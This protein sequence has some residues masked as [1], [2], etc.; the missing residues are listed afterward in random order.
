MEQHVRAPQ[1]EPE[2]GIASDKRQVGAGF[3]DLDGAAAVQTPVLPLNEAIQQLLASM[4]ALVGTA[5]RNARS[6]SDH[7]TLAG[8][9]IIGAPDQAGEFPINLSGPGFALAVR[10]ENSA[11]AEGPGSSERHIYID[12]ELEVPG[13]STRNIILNYQDTTA[14]ANAVP[15]QDGTQHGHLTL[16]IGDQPVHVH[17]DSEMANLTV[18]V[19]LI[20]SLFGLDDLLAF[21]TPTGGIGAGWNT[22]DIFGSAGG[23]EE[24]LRQ[25]STRRR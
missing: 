20:M 11:D 15:T 8:E 2:H 5:N 7:I 3:G 17:F 24:L 13:A 10:S 23:I 25:Y 1:Q 4:S 14:S 6:A 22:S 12:L 18:P 19:P 9:H 16:M 21:G